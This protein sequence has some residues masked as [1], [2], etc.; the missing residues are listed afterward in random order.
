MVESREF[1][2]KFLGLGSGACKLPSTA[3]HIQDPPLHV[4]CSIPHL[5]ADSVDHVGLCVV[6]NSHGRVVM[7][8]SYVLGLI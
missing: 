7:T 8:A 2:L 6:T 1:N 5:C 4:P 3:M